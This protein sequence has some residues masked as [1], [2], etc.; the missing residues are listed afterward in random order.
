[1]ISSSTSDP[2]AVAGAQARAAR[3]LLGWSQTKLADAARVSLSAVKRSEAPGGAAAAPEDQAKIRAALEG[4]GVEFLS[5]ENGG[6]GVRFGSPR[7]RQT[8]MTEDLNAS[9]DE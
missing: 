7:A 5:G 4:A 3:G 9:N 1:M 8:I 2:N 6:A